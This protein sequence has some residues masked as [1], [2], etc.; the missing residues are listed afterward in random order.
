[1]GKTP[2][3]PLPQAFYFVKVLLILFSFL[4]DHQRVGEFP[5]YFGQ[6]L[7]VQIF[8]ETLVVVFKS[9]EAL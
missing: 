1:M 2:T 8:Y 3:T 6:M 9:K 5:F 7:F 4:V